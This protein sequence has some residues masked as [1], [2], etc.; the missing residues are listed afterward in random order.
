MVKVVELQRGQRRPARETFLP[1]PA[2]L[3]ALEAWPVAPP[4]RAPR[5]ATPPLGQAAARC[6]WL[7]HGAPGR[8]EPP[9][10]SPQP[11]MDTAGCRWMRWWQV[12]ATFWSHTLREQRRQGRRWPLFV[13]AAS[14]SG[15]SGKACNSTAH[16]GSLGLQSCYCAEAAAA[17][18]AAARRTQQPVATNLSRPCPRRPDLLVRMPI[19]LFVGFGFAAAARR[20]QGQL[21]MYLSLPV[22]ELLTHPPRRGQWKRLWQFQLLHL[23]PHPMLGPKRTWSP[24]IQ[25]ARA[26]VT[27]AH[28]ASLGSRASRERLANAPLHGRGKRPSDS[29]HL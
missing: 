7:A 4:T 14:G 25:T 22:G 19:V 3:M 1:L 29:R 28:R 9:L 23:I 15:C 6:G 5:R 24:E 17:L 21:Q 2:T 26:H 20:L 13:L 12:P 11:L 27:R 16:G 18:A 8:L 10:Q